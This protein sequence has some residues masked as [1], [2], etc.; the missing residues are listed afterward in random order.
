VREGRT[1]LSVT[2]DVVTHFILYVGDQ[3]RSAAFYSD[4]LRLVPHLDVP[5][6]TEFR[7]SART[8]LGLMPSIG[9]ERL[10]G[11]AMGTASAPPGAVRAEVYLVVE[12]AQGYHERAL[13]SGARELSPLRERDWG[14][15]VAYSVD[16]DGYVLAFASPLQARPN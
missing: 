3:A 2:A 11:E 15:A 1:N 16:A 7:L 8:I 14:H 10:L 5:G 13:A 9:I 4:V 12:D 6:M